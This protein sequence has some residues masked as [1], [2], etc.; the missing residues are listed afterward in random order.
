[1]TLNRVK[2]SCVVSALRRY[3]M[4]SVDYFVV[5]C[6]FMDDWKEIYMWTEMKL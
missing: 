4:H 3:D 2:N 6:C 1:M 5:I